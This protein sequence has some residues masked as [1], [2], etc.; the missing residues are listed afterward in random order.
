MTENSPR[1]GN[2]S[3]DIDRDAADKDAADRLDKAS[4]LLDVRSLV[5]EHHAE[6]YRYAYRLTG[7]QPDAEDLTQQVF[8][9]AQAKIGQL[10]DESR[11]RSWLFTILR[12]AFLKSRSRRRPTSC[13]NL[14]L[15]LENIPEETPD[16]GPYD[17]ERLQSAIDQLPE[18]FKLVLLMYYFED[19][20]Y[21]E[22]AERLEL[23]LGTVMSRLSRAKQHVRRLMVEPEA[24]QASQV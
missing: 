9:V 12:N 14:D 5:R 10:R 22:I 11:R 3:H 16:E 19:C 7:L 17:R 6:L 18:P 8:L 21:R 24:T 15:D 20:S 2:S 4:P 23:P 1:D 13:T